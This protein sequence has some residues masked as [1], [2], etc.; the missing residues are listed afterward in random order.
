MQDPERRSP[1]RWTHTKAVEEQLRQF[2]RELL[3]IIEKRREKRR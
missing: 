1:S 2:F 3:H